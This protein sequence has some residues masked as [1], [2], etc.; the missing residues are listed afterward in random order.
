MDYQRSEEFP[1]AAVRIMDV[2]TNERRNLI[3]MAVQQE[4]RENP[5]YRKALYEGRLPNVK[6]LL[7]SGN[8]REF[9]S[10][11]RRPVL[12]SRAGSQL[13]MKSDGVVPTGRPTGL[14]ARFLSTIYAGIKKVHSR[15]DR[16]SPIAPQASNRSLQSVSPTYSPPTAGPSP[17]DDHMNKPSPP[18]PTEQP[19][20]KPV[21]LAEAAKKII[22]SDSEQIAAVRN[23]LAQHEA[24]RIA[25]G[26]GY[27]SPSALKALADFI[28]VG[29]D[30]KPTI[31]SAASLRTP[32]TKS[33]PSPSTAP[34]HQLPSTA[35]PTHSTTSPKGPAR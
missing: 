17:T 12:R 1:A 29:G 19:P 34:P 23:T 35:A 14:A 25:K 31:A 10:E 6:D 4:I 18:I 33:R 7:T 32:G 26:A 30:H 20:P 9:A 3:K 27:D 13:G 2:R 15:A 21:S 8:I 16:K 28:Q 24:V 11:K 22:Q 5:D